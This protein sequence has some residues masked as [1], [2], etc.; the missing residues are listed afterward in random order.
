MKIVYET[1]Q[2][3]EVKGKIKVQ[4]MVN[5]TD[6]MAK[7]FHLH[8]LIFTAFSTVLQGSS[9]IVPI[10]LGGLSDIRDQ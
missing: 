6:N 9:H 3:S 4:G 5:V 7:W 2:D 8:L 10:L 1:L